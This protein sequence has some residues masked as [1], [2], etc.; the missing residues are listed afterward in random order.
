M[1]WPRRLHSGE[2]FAPDKVVS[3]FHEGSTF[4]ET[5]MSRAQG[6]SLGESA[7]VPVQQFGSDP[8]VASH[9]RVAIHLTGWGLQLASAPDASLA[10]LPPLINMSSAIAR[11]LMDQ[12]SS[13]WHR[14]PWHL[15]SVCSVGCAAGQ[16]GRCSLLPWQRGRLG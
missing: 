16:G 10:Q 13:V 14:Q 4:C 5:C 12:V 3:D 2:L 7:P 6:G 11:R 9:L 8:L 1:G 15:R